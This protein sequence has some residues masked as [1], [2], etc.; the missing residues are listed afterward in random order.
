MND[1]EARISSKMEK[2]TGSSQYTLI[3]YDAM[4]W[5]NE[6][7]EELISINKDGESIV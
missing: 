5:S 3:W 4:S 2:G 1:D 6:I 7:L